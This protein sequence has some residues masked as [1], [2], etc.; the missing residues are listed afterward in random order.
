MYFILENWLTST[1][2]D[3]R[4]LAFNGLRTHFKVLRTF[5]GCTY[6]FSCCQSDTNRFIVSVYATITVYEYDLVRNAEHELYSYKL[7]WRSGS[8]EPFLHLSYQI[9]TGLDVLNFDL[10]PRE[11][12][13]L[14]KACS[15]STFK[16][17]PLD[18]P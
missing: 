12:G 5:L 13:E 10:C 8:Y 4:F 9:V 7:P 14:F 16:L 18:I 2:A 17:P 11:C 6:S 3:V 15:C 1:R